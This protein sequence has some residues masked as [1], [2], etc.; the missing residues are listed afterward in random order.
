MNKYILF[1]VLFFPIFMRSQDKIENIYFNIS[2]SDSIGVEPYQTTKEEKANIDSYKLSVNSKLIG[3]LFLMSNKLEVPV[4]ITDD[5]F[6]DYIYDIGK[7]VVLKVEKE[8]DFFK[9]YYQEEKV[10]GIIYLESKNDILYRFVF[11]FPNKSYLLKYDKI[12]DSM[13]SNIEY[14]KKTW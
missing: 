10:Q 6:K 1:L 12:A 4:T 14:K 9:I 13:F 8:D 7:L 11:M 5:N 2:V 3:I